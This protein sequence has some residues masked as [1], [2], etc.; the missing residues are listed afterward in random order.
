MNLL[1]TN[2]HNSQSYAIIM[3]LRPYAHKIVATM[4]GANRFLPR[5]SHIAHSRFVDRRY[6]V[7]SPVNDWSQ[8]NI[9][10]ENTPREESFVQAVERICEREKIDVIF[11]SWDPHVYVLSKNKPRLG[12]MGIVIPIPDWDTVLMA[13]DKYRTVQAAQEIGFPC[14]RTYLYEHEEQLK[15]ITKKEGFP[16]VIK[17]RISSGGRGMVIVKDYPELLEKLP[18]VIEKHG[19]PMI[20]EYIPGG[21]RVSF[22]VVLDRN[23]DL[24]FV[25]DKKIV[26]NFRVTTRFGAVDESVFLDPQISKNAR[27][28]LKKLG[29]WGSVSVSTLRDPRDGLCKLIEINPRFSRNMWHRTELGVNEPWMCIKIAKREPVDA[30]KEYPEGALLVCPIEDIQLLTLQLID[31]MIYKFRTRVLKNAPVDR[32]SAPKSMREQL[33]SFMR[34]YLSSQKR[35][36]DP[37]FKYFFRDPVV[38]ILWWLR[39]S[40][41]VIGALKHAGR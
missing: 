10:R 21:Q 20:Q 33:H 6:Y 5:F 37:H 23:G 39:F 24:K 1:V 12:R 4:E 19:N 40:T 34:T 9:M 17:P 13:V 22:P 32:F 29:W 41:W 11:P 38:S 2:T 28:L 15:W 35:V 8:G 16:L 25:F 31:L 27:K 3:A 30:P 36:F 26:R 7:P 14:P 18:D